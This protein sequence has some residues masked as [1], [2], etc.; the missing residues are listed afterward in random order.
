GGNN[1]ADDGRAVTRTAAD[2]GSIGAALPDTRDRLATL[3]VH[4]RG[5]ART[6]EPAVTDELARRAAPSVDEQPARRLSSRESRRG[7]WLCGRRNPAANDCAD[8]N[9]PLLRLGSS[10]HAIPSFA[11]GQ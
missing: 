9:H 5:L 1:A 8:K 2:H 7:R 10:L 11:S 6:A 3:A 4:E